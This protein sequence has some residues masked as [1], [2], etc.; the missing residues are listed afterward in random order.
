MPKGGHQPQAR[1]GRICDGPDAVIN[2]LLDRGLRV[3]GPREVDGAITHK[4]LG[5]AG[6]M[7]KGR[8]DDQAPGRYRL[9]DGDPDRWFD[10]VVGPDSWKSWLFPARRKL[11]SAHKTD[12]GLSFEEPVPHW[13]DTAF[14]G[15][16]PC[17]LAAI[18]R[19]RRVFAEGAF[20]DPDYF[21]RLERTLI[22]VVQCA[23]AAPT[24]FCA[25]MDTGP[26]AEDGYD[27]ALTE[28]TG[29]RVLIEA[30]SEAGQQILDT[31]PGDPAGDDDRAQAQA[32]SAATAASQTRRMPENVA[33]GLKDRIAAPVWDEIA[34]TCLSC[35]NCTL[36]CPTCFCSDVEDITDLSGDHAERW[37]VWDSCFTPDFSYIHGG[38]VRTTTSGRYRQWM[39]HKL[40]Y[41][42]DQFD[43][44]GCVGCGRCI[45][46]CPVGIDITAMAQAVLD[47][48]EGESA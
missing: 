8:I 14:F 32:I 34:K 25:A 47:S 19:Q 46:W 15:V 31:L 37:Q 17:E 18:G 39:M 23:R 44:S 21:D 48:P 36:A 38:P 29:G 42:H 10:Y 33:Q 27:L 40:S 45:A 35:A 3:I 16:R 43:S 6:D 11:W 41:W 22:V 24:C 13:P 30:G 5:G 7:P 28:L 9:R 2:A 26:R 20:G 1:S 12:D 4:P